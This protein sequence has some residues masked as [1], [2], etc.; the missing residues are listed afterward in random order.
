MIEAAIIYMMSKPTA[1]AQEATTET[2]HKGL[3]WSLILTIGALCRLNGA[4]CV[5]SMVIPYTKSVRASSHWRL[6]SYSIMC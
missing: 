5:N 2:E 4:G 6:D 3:V 1:H